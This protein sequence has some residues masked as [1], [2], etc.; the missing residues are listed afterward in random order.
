[1][2]A[3]IKCGDTVILKTGNITGM[4]TG[5]CI[6]FDRVQYEFSYFYS[7]DIRTAWISENEMTVNPED[8]QAIGFNNG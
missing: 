6:R 7:G 5:I 1:M 8:K 4:V 3:N 2:E